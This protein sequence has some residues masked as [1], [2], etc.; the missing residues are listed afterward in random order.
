[1]PV[2][3]AGIIYKAIQRAVIFFLAKM[4]KE[5]RFETKRLFP[6]PPSPWLRSTNSSRADTQ[7]I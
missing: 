7:E 2:N 5:R 1:M 4:G 6:N 3:P